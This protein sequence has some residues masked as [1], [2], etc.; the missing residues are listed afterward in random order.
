M[1]LVQIDLQ[2]GPARKH[3][4]GSDVA[5]GDHAAAHQAATSAAEVGEP[6]APPVRGDSLAPA[7]AGLVLAGG[8]VL[9]APLAAAAAGSLPTRILLLAGLVALGLFTALLRPASTGAD[10]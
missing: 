4:H 5:E 3:T 2:R 10:P 1:A 7:T 6:R 9:L 8:L